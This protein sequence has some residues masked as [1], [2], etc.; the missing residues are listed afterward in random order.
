M[1]RRGF[2]SK[3]FGRDTDEDET[4]LYPFEEIGERLAGKEEPEE[5]QRRG[6]TIKR[7]AEIIDDLPPDVPR[8]SALRIVRRTLAAT[9]IEIEDIERSTRARETR[10]G[11]EIDLARS[12]QKGLQEKT[13]E[14][15]RSL[16]EEI[17]K[18]R[19][20]CE[21]SIAEEEERASRA[22]A[23][24]EEVRRVRAFFGF[25]KTEEISNP[26]DD[27]SD[28]TQ[29]LEPFDEDG[30]QATVRPASLADR[31][32]DTPRHGASSGTTDER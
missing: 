20:A 32:K 6:F 11:S 23:S 22:S 29:V 28:D 21:T 5:G 18:A 10:H 17:R 24:L 26:M 14:V 2:L 3:I 7:A 30:T 31:S 15:V 25:P 8:E 19:E 16:E 13:E 4:T 9:G 1:S 12:R 27:A